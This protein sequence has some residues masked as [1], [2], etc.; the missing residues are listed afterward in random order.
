MDLPV[1]QLEQLRFYFVSGATRPYQFRRTQLVKLR[2]AILD[3]EQELHTA[4]YNDLKKSPEESWVT[5]TGFLIAEINHAIRHLH[6]WMK[7]KKVRTN[8]LNF[9]A[10]SYIY[11][12]PLGVV[13][14]IGAWNYPLQLLLAPM[15]GAI[16]AGNCIVL[17]P[18]EFS[19]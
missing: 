10:K 14:I 15:V 8:L 1:N 3:H 2:Q 5:E 18:S 6:K 11:K 13:L 4:L 7:R 19:T 17:K 9:P 16:A 12:E